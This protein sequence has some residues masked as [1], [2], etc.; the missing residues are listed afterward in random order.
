MKTDQEKFFIEL[1]NI[2][3]TALLKSKRLQLGLIDDIDDVVRNNQ[4]EMDDLYNQSLLVEGANQIVQ[5]TF[6]EKMAL[7]EQIRELEDKQELQVRDW[8]M[9]SQVHEIA[10]DNIIEIHGKI[11]LYIEEITSLQQELGVDIP[12]DKYYQALDDNDKA[13]QDNIITELPF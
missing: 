2:K 4:A 11:V 3:K 12:M 10:M 7:E 9:E 13:R 5:E 6:Q 8:N 1:K